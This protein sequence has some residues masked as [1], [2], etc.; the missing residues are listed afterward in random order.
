VVVYPGHGFLPT[1]E[2]ELAGSLGPHVRF[3]S[4]EAL[5]DVVS[6]NPALTWDQVYAAAAPDAL[7]PSA[8]PASAATPA[9]PPATP[10]RPIVALSAGTADDLA[11]LGYDTD[12]ERKSLHVDTA[13]LRLCRVLLR[14]NVR[15]AY[16]G[17]MDTP[18]ASGGETR[19]GVL[20]RD[21]AVALAQ[22]PGFHYGD[23]TRAEVDPETP[24]EMWLPR[25][26]GA[27]YS[28]KARADL[29][30]LC[31]FYFVGDDAPAGGSPQDRAAAIARARSEGRRAVADH[32]ELAICLSGKRWG[33]SGIMPGVA[34]EI[35]CTTE[36]SG[37]PPADP[38]GVRVLLLGEFGGV[39]REIVRYII[40]A[41]REL[42]PALVLPE[43]EAHPSGTLRALLQHA[44]DL[45]PIAEQ[46][47]AALARCLDG[48]R[49]VANLDDGVVLEH[50]GI[51][52]RAWRDVM[53]TSSLG[54]VRRLLQRQIV[55]VL[56][57]RAAQ[58]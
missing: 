19:F 53:I 13:V 6:T 58:V 22:T 42:P 40:G 5:S 11:A 18:T 20:L 37:R 23:R 8:T 27:E 14:S 3:L 21:T 26:Y 51:T 49:E 50:L 54:H 33:F 56:K 35:L 32:T 30:G 29:T 7:P 15:I 39:T 16:G 25:P 52:V 1:D 12:P 24:L 43:Q 28:I 45:R 17:R 9:A 46:R 55:P 10:K 4:F 31:R 57:A 47:Y 34:E 41:A 38:R 2:E 36:A 44:P 48:L